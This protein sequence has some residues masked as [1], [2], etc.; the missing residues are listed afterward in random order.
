MALQSW[1]LGEIIK[2]HTYV[3]EIYSTNLENECLY[4]SNHFLQKLGVL[5]D[6][7][8]IRWRERREINVKVKLPNNTNPEYRNKWNETMIRESKDRT[9]ITMMS[10]FSGFF[11]KEVVLASSAWMG[12]FESFPGDEVVITPFIK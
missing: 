2:N 4:A 1:D 5:Y 6:Y 3:R 7:L 12:E 10:R 8:G 9:F 11:K